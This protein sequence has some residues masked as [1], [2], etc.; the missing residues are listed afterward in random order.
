MAGR[1]S[2]DPSPAGGG[3]VPCPAATRVQFP[4]RAPVQ[5][6]L[7]PAVRRLLWRSLLHEPSGRRGLYAHDGDSPGGSRIQEAARGLLPFSWWLANPG[8]DSGRASIR[9][10]EGREIRRPWQQLLSD[11]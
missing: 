11:P 10:L 1:M 8:G 9:A 4:P 3:A 5:S 2:S 7:A 6:L